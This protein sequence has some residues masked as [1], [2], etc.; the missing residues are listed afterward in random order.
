MA[1]QRLAVILLA[2]IGGMFLAGCECTRA[3]F[4]GLYENVSGADWRRTMQDCQTAWDADQRTWLGNIQDELSAFDSN[5]SGADWRRTM[6]DCQAAWDAD[7]R[8]RGSNIQ[9]ELS[10]L[11]GNVTGADWRENVAGSCGQ[12]AGSGRQAQA[13]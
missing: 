3:Q 11:K 9:D 7:Q 8:T 4:P 6:K 13:E 10:A 5:V 2:A 1:E 12:P